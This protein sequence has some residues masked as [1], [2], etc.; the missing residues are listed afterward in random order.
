MGG[1]EHSCSPVNL[2][3]EHSTA[4]VWYQKPLFTFFFHVLKLFFKKQPGISFLS[5]VPSSTSPQSNIIFFA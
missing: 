5:S 2:S 1:G 4:G 3:R